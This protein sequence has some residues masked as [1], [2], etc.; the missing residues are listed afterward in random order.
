MGGVGIR[1]LEVTPMATTIARACK[2]A[3]AI[4]AGIWRWRSILDER[5]RAEFTI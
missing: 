2:T 5:V 3:E 1:R 4:H